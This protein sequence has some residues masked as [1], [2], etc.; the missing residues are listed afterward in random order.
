MCGICGWFVE[1][2]AAEAESATL[3]KM[4]AALSHRGPDDAGSVVFPRAAL[5]MSRLSVIDLHTGHQ[6]MSNEAQTIWI[7]FNGE[8][9]NFAELRRELRNLLQREPIAQR[10]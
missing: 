6:P 9:Y 8:I 7:V 4:N 2:S 10:V 3:L 1:R 5:A